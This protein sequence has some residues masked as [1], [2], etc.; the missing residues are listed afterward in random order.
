MKLADLAEK[1]KTLSEEIS[2]LKSHADATL[3]KPAAARPP[4]VK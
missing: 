1:N 2:Y 3:P 4:R